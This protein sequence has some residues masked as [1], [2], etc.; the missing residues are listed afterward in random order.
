MTTPIQ[1]AIEIVTRLAA[2]GRAPDSDDKAAFAMSSG[3]SAQ[4]RG[5][6]AAEVM[7]ASDLVECYLDPSPVRRRSAVAAAMVARACAIGATA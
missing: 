1:A 4:A 3:L 2:E 7:A 5:D 6:S